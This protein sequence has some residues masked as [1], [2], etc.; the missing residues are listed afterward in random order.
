MFQALLRHNEEKSLRPPGALHP[1]KTMKG[2]NTVE[3]LMWSGW[4]MRYPL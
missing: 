2:N 3:Q 4:A 1:G